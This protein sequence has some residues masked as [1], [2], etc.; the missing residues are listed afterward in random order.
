[1][2][3]KNNYVN[4]TNMTSH[5]NSPI[6]SQDNIPNHVTKTTAYV[7][8]NVTIPTMITVNPL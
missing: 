7:S 5:N 4:Q 2:K 1:M 8:N 6:N 3:N